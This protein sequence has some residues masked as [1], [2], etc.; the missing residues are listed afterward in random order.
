M[1]QGPEALGSYG[2]GLNFEWK[3]KSKYISKCLELDD[4]KIL[5]LMLEK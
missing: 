4:R 2:W 1:R 3:A 5:M